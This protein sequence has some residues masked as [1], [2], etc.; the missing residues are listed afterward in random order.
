MKKFIVFL[1]LCCLQIPSNIYGQADS[2]LQPDVD[3]AYSFLDN[4]NYNLALKE[5]LRVHFYNREGVAEGSMINDIAYCFEQIGDY[6]N[7]RKYLSKYLRQQDLSVSDRKAASYKKVQLLL[8]SNPQLALAELYQ[9][10]N[11]LILSDPDKYN[12]YEAMVHYANGKMDLCYNALSKLSYHSSV[13]KV[14]YEKLKKEIG[15]NANKNHNVARFLSTVV[16][17]LGQTVN[18]DVQDGINSAIINGAMI[19]LFFYVQ[20]NLSLGDAVI[21]VLPWFGRFYVGGMQNAKSASKRKQEL[22]KGQYLEELNIL[23]MKAKNS[24]TTN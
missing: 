16:P 2:H 4:G 1:C 8:L 12:Y 9:L 24:A 7:S 6:Q 3:L 22:R 11:K 17:G 14:A 15:S 19:V 23:L 21:S 10:S 5:L 18:G 20:G 13:D